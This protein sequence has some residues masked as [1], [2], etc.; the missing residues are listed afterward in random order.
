MHYPAD[1]NDSQIVHNFILVLCAFLEDKINKGI[2]DD[3]ESA[4]ILAGVIA[5]VLMI[6]WIKKLQVLDMNYAEILLLHELPE[7][8]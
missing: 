5:A 8:G 4:T 7:S 1:T 3:N 6:L 2:N